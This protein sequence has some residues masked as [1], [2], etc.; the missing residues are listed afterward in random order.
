MRAWSLLTLLNVACVGQL[1]PLPPLARAARA[2]DVATLR[3]MV[4]QGAPLEERSG[5][6]G[7]TALS[8]AVHTEQGSAVEVLL[9]LG[10]EANARDLHGATAL[11]LAAGQAQPAAVRQLLAHG[12]DPGARSDLGATA[13]S[14]AVAAGSAE[15]IDALL[16]RDGRLALDRGWASRASVWL[17]RLRGRGDL[18][19]RI[20]VDHAQAKR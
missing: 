3:R 18:V 11:M 7:W 14:N 4:S 20:R 10:A 5:V 12:A 9:E 17:A 19:A 8:H 13:L 1:A 15:V 6:N 2:G 16:A